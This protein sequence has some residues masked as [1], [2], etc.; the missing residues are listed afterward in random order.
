MNTSQDAPRSPFRGWKLVMQIFAKYHTEFE[1]QNITSFVGIDADS[2]TIV[3]SQEINDA[4]VSSDRGEHLSDYVEVEHH[5]EYFIFECEAGDLTHVGGKEFERCSNRIEFCTNNIINAYF[6]SL[7][8][9]NYVIPTNQNNTYRFI[10]SGPSYISHQLIQ[11]I[12]AFQ[13]AGIKTQKRL[14]ISNRDEYGDFTMKG[15]TVAPLTLV[16]W[17]K[18]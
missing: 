15:L 2:C 17:L 13:Y 1:N 11:S 18:L 8:S 10:S 12:I 9:T 7:F 4:E 5:G 6:V 3:E 16:T 14:Y